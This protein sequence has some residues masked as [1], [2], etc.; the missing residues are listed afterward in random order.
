MRKYTKIFCFIA[1]LFLAFTCKNAD[2][3]RETILEGE[4]TVIAD[5]TLAPIVDDQ[6]QVFE[7]LYNA[8]INIEPKSE[9]EA[10]QSLV[11]DSSRIAVLARKLTGDEIKVFQKRKLVPKVTPF[12][13]D[14]IALI[15]NRNNKDTLIAL[16]EVIDFMQ[17][18]GST[19][20]K[21]VVFDNPNSSTARYITSLAELENLPEKGVFSFK[22][23]NEVIKYV[24]EN[25]G[26]IG[27][28]GVNYIYQP[29]P[30][31][32]PFMDK[33]SVLSVKN[34]NDNMYYAPT[35]NSIAEGKYPLAR[36]LYIV[37]CQGYSGLGMGF[38]SF[39]AGET[40]QRIVLKSGLVPIRVPSRKILIRNHI[41]ND[42]K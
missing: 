22:T 5:E 28:V 7:S 40:G 39:I 42:K 14:A 35:Q 32:N 8:K 37:N 11:N 13:K 12:A 15:T 19:K 30:G 31:M 34:T 16:Q 1:F 6:V 26:M 36:D 4:T 2:A 10:I 24:A 38:A 41:N 25:E 33:I 18:K 20:F 17:G 29:M 21:G 9:A 23:N 27:V 3:K